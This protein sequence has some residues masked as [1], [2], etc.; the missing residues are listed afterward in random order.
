MKR[1]YVKGD[2]GYD[3]TFTLTDADGNA[4]DLTNQTSIVL[5]L[6]R[7]EDTT[8]KLLGACS[9]VG[10]PTDGICKYAVQSGDF[11]EAALY[12]GSIV[13]TFSS[14]RQTADGFQIEIKDE[15]P[16]T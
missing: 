3:I 5:R 10:T 7:P 1:T 8:A 12:D 14:A 13:V 6:A 4:V 16:S 2:Y 9:V 15:L 11:D